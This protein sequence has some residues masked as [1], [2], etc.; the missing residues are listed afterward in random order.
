MTTITGCIVYNRG[1]APEIDAA[2]GQGWGWF[3]VVGFGVFFTV[4]TIALT[5]FEQK[6]LGTSMSSEQFN[7]AGRNVGVGL[8][9]AV[10]VSQWTWAA[11][12]LM[13]SNMGWRVGVSG[14]FWYAS[15]ATV[16]ILLFAIL[17]IQVKRR[18]SHM[19]TFMEIVKARFGTVTHCIMIV[20]ALLAN[21]IVTAML[22]LGGAATIS[23]LTGMSKI[24]AAFL[25][26]LL[27]CWIYTMHGGL[28]ATFFASYVHTTV[29]FL[30]LLIFTFSVYGGATD[31]EFYGSASKVY[32]GLQGAAVHGIFEA[33][34]EEAA[35]TGASIFPGLG[36]F[37]ANDGTCHGSDKKDTGK[38]CKFSTRDAPCCSAD[39]YIPL[40]NYCRAADSDCIDTSAKDHYETSDCDFA[41][42][43]RC[44]P[45]FLTMGS[46]SG[47]LFGITNIV[48]NF[49]TVFVDQSYWQSAV[50]AK[51]KSAV[52]GFLIGGMVWFAVPFCMATTN[53]LVGRAIT[54]DPTLT[55]TYIDAGAS[56]S[57]LTPARVLSHVM[58]AGGAF[59]LLLQLFM[60]ITSTGSAEIIAV[61]SILTYDIYYEYINPEL[62]QRREGMRKTFNEAV[63]EFSSEGAAVPVSSI[64]PLM[65]KLV[66]RKFFEKEV[67]EAE[68]K[69]LATAIN[70]F[71][72]SQS[73]KDGSIKTSDLYAAVNRAVA[74]NNIEGVILLRVSKFFTAVFAIFMGF[75]AVFLQ[76][77][78]FSL[79]WVYMSMGVLIGSAVGPASLTILMEKASSVA[80]GA[81]AVGGLI[82]GMLGWI[83][84]ALI[85]SEEV[86]YDSLGSDWPWVVG[87]LCAIFGG[88]LISL[89]GSL[90]K[91]DTEFKWDMLN[92]R[93]PLVDDIEP[94]KDA[95][96]SDEKLQ[97]QVKI[98]VIASVV[99]TLVLLVL[100][101]LP[102]HSFAGVFGKGGF[103]FW[104][105]VE[106]MWALIGGIVIIGLPVAETVLSFKKA[107][108]TK[109]Q[110]G[111]TA[112]QDARLTGINEVL[113]IEVDAKEN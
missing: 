5:Q 76:T 22:L 51:P 110:E 24:W 75:L 48:G 33:T 59:I 52:M 85:E 40:H 64:N 104:V 93:I 73:G 25:I 80:I 96:E 36:T 83:I 7:T 78:G 45:S 68:V 107:R 20:F 67:P 11:T 87:N 98:A 63:S 99:L 44:V 71:V 17:A 89:V 14:P 31:N 21:M 28:K 62:K 55:P 19:H 56:G 50:A 69:N 79:G 97:K 60:A 15:G 27:S 82:M 54:L 32:D 12:L 2:L 8:T 42:G 35:L 66:A 102:M 39:A 100:W 29:I 95:D 9:A 34:Q 13:S 112:V 91:P 53:G 57:G 58:G 46:P 49:G 113:K 94:P 4:F 92:E 108:Q 18:A 16:Q 101:P 26:P 37:I 86:T 84:Q 88:L 74:S 38:F 81:G 106:I 103:T 105:V 47:A 72:D 6:V 109:Q 111:E 3:V 41:A 90:I 70:S 10:I 65:K 77:L 43:E 23:D 61:S 1:E 30:M